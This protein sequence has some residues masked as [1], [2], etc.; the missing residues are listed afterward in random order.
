VGT[1]I[2]SDSNRATAESKLAR[3]VLK[4]TEEQRKDSVGAA[5]AGSQTPFMRRGGAQGQAWL[6]LAASVVIPGAGQLMTGD[7]V[8]GSVMV[9]VDILG[10]IVLGIF[11]TIHSGS[12][13]SSLLVSP[14][15][16]IALGP[17]I[18]VW[19]YALVDLVLESKRA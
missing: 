17:L 16:W 7:T 6:P 2:A 11:A 5:Y 3:A 1:A 14:A 19:I 9:G 10:L 12:R 15:V 13:R 4:R 8:K 18:A